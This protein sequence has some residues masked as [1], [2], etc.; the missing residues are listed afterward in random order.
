VNDAFVTSHP[1]PYEYERITAPTLVISAADDLFGTYEIGRY[2][3]EHI[4]DARF[5]GY[6]SGGHVWIGHDAEMKATVIE[7]LDAA[8]GRT[9]AQH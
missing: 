9:L 8:V 3:A 4:R 2:V 1:R 5:V 7:F 6:P